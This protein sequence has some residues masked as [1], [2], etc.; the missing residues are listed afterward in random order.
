MAFGMFREI[1]GRIIMLIMA[2]GKIIR[3]PDIYLII[4]IAQNVNIEVHDY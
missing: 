2:L 4:L 1:V 3:L